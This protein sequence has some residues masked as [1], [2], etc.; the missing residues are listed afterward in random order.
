MNDT[1]SNSQQEFIEINLKDLIL[2]VF[3]HWKKI[4]CIALIVAVL[5]SLYIGVKEIRVLSDKDAA[6]AKLEEYNNLMEDYE[7]SSAQLNK[8]IE[9]CETELTRQEKYRESALILFIDPYDVHTEKITYFVDTDYEIIPSQYYQDPNH[10]A[11]VANAYVSEIDSIDFD[12]VLN[13]DGEN[14]LTLY[15]P[16]SG[17]AL[18]LV[19][20]T[21]NGSGIVE[22]TI[23][24]D[25]D[26][27]LDLIKS[28][29]VST[30]E[31]RQAE[32]DELICEHA[33][34]LLSDVRKVSVNKDFVTLRDSFNKNF[35]TLSTDLEKSKES[36][37]ELTMPTNTAPSKKN[38]IKNTVKYF[39]IGFILGAV[40]SVLAIAIYLILANKMMNPAD[41][42]RR[43]SLPVLGTLSSGAMPKM[44]RFAASRLGMST[45]SSAE[46]QAKYIENKYLLHLD[47]YNLR[48]K[49][50][51][52]GTAGAEAM[53]NVKER[54]TQVLDGPEK[55]EIIVAG[56]VN[57]SS[58]ALEILCGRVDASIVCVEKWQKS[59]MGDIE[60]EMRIIKASEKN[61]VGVVVVE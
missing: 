20:A 37:S 30:L 32:F 49:I 58:N 47:D 8:K 46:E 5:A 41:I 4:L 7:R 25:S 28:S 59:N 22:I 40:I 38:A 10:T 18:K 1:Q 33:L 53:E 42:T 24:A 35:E 60:N 45:D 31:N 51:L 26:E 6:E 19:N 43:Y 50:I 14:N 12:A 61:L 55:P 16:V 57:K 2:S 27:R 48:H 17:N 56:D 29:I 9:E 23:Y 54:L 15:N 3:L 36:L 11:T 34:K 39:V 21:A 44:K 52:I 13:E